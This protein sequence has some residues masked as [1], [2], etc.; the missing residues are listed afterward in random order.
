[1]FVLMMTPANVDE[2]PSLFL[3]S[4]DNFMTGHKV[5]VHIIHTLSMSEHL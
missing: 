1:M 4:G 3:E 2:D 5:I